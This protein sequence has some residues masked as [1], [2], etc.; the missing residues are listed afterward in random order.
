MKLMLIFCAAGILLLAAAVG[1][2]TRTPAQWVAQLGAQ[3][4][5]DRDAASAALLDLG[6]KARGDVRHALDSNDP[7]VLARAKELWKTLHWLVV[8]DADED[9]KKL[10]DEADQGGI[11]ASHWQDFVQ[12]YG[13]ESIRLVAEFQ[14]SGSPAKIYQPGLQAVLDDAPPMEVARIIAQADRTDARPALET[15]LDELQPAGA[16]EKTA[17]NWMQIQI[18]LWNYDK[19]YSFGRD[20]SF[21]L[22]SDELVKQCAI[23][24]DR[25]ALF[26]KIHIDAGK[27][28]ASE[29]DPD[30]LCTK[31]SFYIGLF[32]ELEK[33]PLIDPL[34]TMARDGGIAKADDVQLRHIVERLWSAGQ[35]AL[36][37][38]VLHNVQSP[39]AL[40]MR[41]VTDLQIQDEPVA[42]TDWHDAMVALD[43]IPDGKK[44]EAFYEMAELMNDW[45]DNR[46]AML[47]QKILSMPP[48][49]TV[50][51]ANACFRLG[52]LMEQQGQYNQAA[53]IYEKGLQIAGNL[54]GFLMATGAKGMAVSGEKIMRQKIKNLRSLANGQNSLFKDATSS[55]P[56]TVP[57]P[58]GD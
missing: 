17:V 31:L 1:E 53:D 27:D 14:A 5:E 51:D 11:D 2:E 10:T 57:Q 37:V 23:A 40:Y 12:K 25:G 38:K 3:R 18:A 52:Q 20:V 22:V 50:Y 56:D 49:T 15:L 19:A 32:S 26:G 39:M 44:K 21:R 13:A 48:Q 8:G 42:A 9:I 7:E 36:A 35:P 28:I 55:N 34:L 4:L 45:H 30:R 6:A 33:K 29:T 41:S 16:Q 24:A 47:W 43:A 46:A 54:G 58:A